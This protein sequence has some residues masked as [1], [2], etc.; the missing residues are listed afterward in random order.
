MGMGTE[1]SNLRSCKS[2]AR[3]TLRLK[4]RPKG[5][6]KYIE[7]L[8]ER[9]NEGLFKGPV[10]VD[11]ESLIEPHMFPNLN[12]SIDDSRIIRTK[13]ADAKK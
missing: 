7:S 10:V 1:K 12:I 11:A 6:G 9:L 3:F 2:I 5:D 13:R 4:L 8:I